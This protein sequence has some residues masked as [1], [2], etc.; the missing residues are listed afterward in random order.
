MHNVKLIK[1]VVTALFTLTTLAALVT[2]LALYQIGLFGAGGIPTK[3]SKIAAQNDL[4]NE[5][6]NYR[7][8]SEPKLTILNPYTYMLL[9]GESGSTR[10]STAVAVRVAQSQQLETQKYE[11]Q[12]WW[13]ISGA[14]LTIWLTRN[15]SIEEL[16]SK[17][18]E[19]RKSNAPTI[20]R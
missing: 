13:H 4:Q 7:G 17:S 5:W 10:V 16:L 18:H 9:A 6:R 1:R 11:S 14:A 8:Q 19:L 20:D 2:P 15:W 12:S 3:P